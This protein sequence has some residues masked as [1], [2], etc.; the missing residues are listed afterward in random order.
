LLEEKEA[1]AIPLLM[2]K[3]DDEG[4]MLIPTRLETTWIMAQSLTLLVQF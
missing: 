1:I 3:S 2:P 4:T